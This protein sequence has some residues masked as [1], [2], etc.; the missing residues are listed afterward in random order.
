MMVIIWFYG[1]LNHKGD[2]IIQVATGLVRNYEGNY[3]VITRVLTGRL[4]HGVY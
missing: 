3:D 2:L 4:V 1:F